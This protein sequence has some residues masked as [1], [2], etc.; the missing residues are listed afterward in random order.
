MKAIT[1]N[2]SRV[3]RLLARFGKAQLIKRLD[4]AVR[5]RGGNRDE[6]QDARDWMSMFLHEASWSPENER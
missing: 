2:P 5:L 4:G 1:L 6:R 3:E